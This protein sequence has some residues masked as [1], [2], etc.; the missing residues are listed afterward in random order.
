MSYG[1]IISQE[2]AEEAYERLGQWRVKNDPDMEDEDAER[3]WG[4]LRFVLQYDEA[5]PAEFIENQGFSEDD[6]DDD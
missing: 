4:F 5:T 6:Y 2:Q 1:K 3:L